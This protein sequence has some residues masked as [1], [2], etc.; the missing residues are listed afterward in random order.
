MTTSVIF[1]P[2]G[3]HFKRINGL[4]RSQ[5]KFP[6]WLWLVLL[7][8]ESAGLAPLLKKKME[9]IREGRKEGL[10]ENHPMLKALKFR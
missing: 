3:F 6:S 1:K 8:S 2:N 10:K 4:Y 7:P 9:S 5:L